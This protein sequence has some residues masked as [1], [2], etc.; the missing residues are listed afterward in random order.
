MCDYLAT[1]CLYFRASGDAFGGG[2]CG[3]GGLFHGQ[4]DR[5]TGWA[6]DTPGGVTETPRPPARGTSAEDTGRWRH[7]ARLLLGC[8]SRGGGR[9]MTE[10]RLMGWESGA[11]PRDGGRR[12]GWRSREG[13]TAPGAE[14][15]GVVPAVRRRHACIANKT[16]RTRLRA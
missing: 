2:I 11:Q 1:R 5:S 4:R 9:T 7:P 13:G 8:R 16:A 3:G 15:E 12:L 10:C 14:A 6:V